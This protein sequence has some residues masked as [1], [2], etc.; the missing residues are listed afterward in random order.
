LFLPQ[1]LRFLKTKVVKTYLSD[2]GVNIGVVSQNS[3]QERVVV[4]DM[5]SWV[6]VDLGWGQTE[7]RPKSLTIELPTMM[8]VVME[9]DGETTC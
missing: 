3:G 6:T 8:V 4:M 9:S 2:D 1:F 5:G 7:G